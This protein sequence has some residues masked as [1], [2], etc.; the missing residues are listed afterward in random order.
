[1]IGNAYQVNVDMFKILLFQPDRCLKILY[2]CQ[3]DNFQF[4]SQLVKS[5]QLYVKEQ[6]STASLVQNF[7]ISLV[8]QNAE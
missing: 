5:K 4:K 2:K 3:W 1:M 7:T 8:A 6:P